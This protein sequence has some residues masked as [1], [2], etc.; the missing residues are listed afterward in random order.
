MRR[1][2]TPDAGGRSAP[3]GS[4]T[5]SR[6]RGDRRPPPSARSFV[7]RFAL[8]AM[9]ALAVVAVATAFVS[10]RV[11]E[12]EGIEE[13][14]RIAFASGRGVVQPA[15]TDGIVEIAPEAVLALDRIV[16]DAVLRGS[17]VRVKLWREDGTIVYSDEGRLIGRRYALAPDELAILN[18]GQ[19]AA[20]V[21]NLE[22][23][24]N[25]FEAAQGKLLETYVRVRTPGGTPLLFEAYFRYERVVDVGQNIWLSFAFITIG[26]L[27]VLQ[28]VQ[29]PLAWSLA[30]SLERSQEQRELLLRHAVEASDRERRRIAQD[31]HDGVVQDLTGVSYALAARALKPGGDPDERRLLEETSV[32]VRDSIGALRSLLVDIYPPSLRE[33]GLG[34]A[35]D[36]LVAGLAGRGITVRV[37]IEVD[38]RVL[39]E[40]V[41]A[42]LYRGAQEAVRNVATHAGAT[43]VSIRVASDSE[44]AYLVVEDDGRGFEPALTGVATEPGH[45]GLRGLSDLVAAV[46][47]TVE[48][49]S[50]PDRG[51]ELRVEI[52]VVP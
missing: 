6:S 13:A 2:T 51:T 8:V 11:A 50:A 14:K 23:P 46:G 43:S 49:A 45:V 33:E 30:S 27:V 26:A 22:K 4:A 15:L 24:E 29:L 41:E 19:E 34:T 5:P 40:D 37:E 17:L 35:L 28:L 38:D 7:L 36:N 9:L 18:G 21:S 31:L 52:P 20:E 47:G 10:R 16:K 25:R 32:Q 48:V 3:A 44:R 42:L 12:R 39:P 1:V